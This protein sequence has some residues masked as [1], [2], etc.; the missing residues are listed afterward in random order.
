MSEPVEN[1]VNEISTSAITAVLSVVFLLTRLS[2]F[3]IDP[4]RRWRRDDRMV[5][6]AWKREAVRDEICAA[7][8]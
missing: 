3:V 7:C 2:G 1:Y 8:D 5:R 6:C 4:T